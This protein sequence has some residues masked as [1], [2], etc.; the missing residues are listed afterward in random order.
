M[1]LLPV[2]CV[3]LVREGASVGSSPAEM[4]GSGRD[5]IW[6]KLAKWQWLKHIG[7][8]FSHEQ[9]SPEEFVQAGAGALSFSLT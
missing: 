1:A 6:L 3:T 2:S 9:R 4:S 5:C 7:L 8:Y